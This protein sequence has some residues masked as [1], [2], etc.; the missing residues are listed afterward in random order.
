MENLSG[1][2]RP[3]KKALLSTL[4][5]STL[6]SFCFASG[7]GSADRFIYYITANAEPGGTISPSG[8]V[9]VWR[10]GDKTFEISA[11]TGFEIQ[12][13]LVDG[14]NKGALSTYTFT[15]VNDDHTITASFLARDY[16]IK[17]TAGI[18]GSITPSGDVK[19]KR[20]GKVTFNIAADEG[21]EILDVLVDGESVGAVSRYEFTKVKT[22]HTIHATFKSLFG[23]QDVSIPNESMKIGDVV[24]TTV[25]VSDDSGTPYS[26]VSGSVG[27]YPLVDFQR[28]SATSYLANFSISEGGASFAASEEIP[29]DNLVLSAGG[30]LSPPYNQ[31]IQ[32]DSDPLDAQLP[33]ISSMQVEGGVK[34]IG[35][36]VILTIEADGIS[37]TLDPLST[38]NGMAAT[39]SNMTF[40]ES[41]GGAY[42]L[43]YKVHTGDPDVGPGNQELTAS[44]ILVKPSGNVS[45]PYTTV[46]NASG[47]TIDAHAPVVSRVEVPSLTVGVGGMV[48]ITITA[49]G[50]GYTPGPGSLVNGVPLSSPR[51]TFVEL[52]NG[53]Y[54]L[55]YA[56]DHEDEDVAV[57]MLQ[58]SIQLIDEAGNNSIPYETIEPNSLEIYTTLPEASLGGVPQVC[59]GDEVELTVF[60]SGRMPLSFEMDDGTTTTPYTN[61]TSPEIHIIVAPELT[62]TYQIKSLTDVNGVTN[63]VA[64][65]MQVIVSEIAEV[66]I[67]NL[68][69]GYNVEADGVKL[70]ANIPGGLFS[71]PGVVSSSDYFYPNVA[72]TINSPHTI[73]YTYTNENNCQSI[74]SKLVYV[75]GADGAIVIPEATVC[76][77]SD[78]FTVNVLNIPGTTGTFRLLNSSAQPVSGLTDIGDNTA[79]IDPSLLNP[80]DY[81][82]EF[83][84]VDKVTL[85]LRKNFSVVSNAPPQILTSIDNSYCQDADSFELRSN[86][87]TAIFEGPGVSGNI[88]DGFIFSPMESDPGQI[89]ITCSSLYGNGCSASSEVNVLIMFA[90]EVMFKVNSECL[91][92]GGETVNFENQTPGKSNIETW[93]WDFGD[94]LSGQDNHSNLENPVHHYQEPGLKQISLTA[95]TTEGCVSSYELEASIDSHPE[96]N[97][98]WLSNCYIPGAD[99]KFV[100]RSTGAGSFDTIIWTFRNSTGDLLAEVASEAV[101]DTVAFLFHSAET[102]IVELYTSNGGGCFDEITKQVELGP[103]IKLDSEGYLETYD[104]TEGLWT[105]GSEEQVASWTWGEPNFSGYAGLPDDKAWYTLLPADADYSENS[106]IQSPCFDLTE[107]KR[108][109]IRIDMMRSFVPGMNGAVLQY[110]DVIEEGWKTIGENSPGIGWYNDEHIFNQPGGSSVGWGLEEFT[111]DTD[112]VTAVHDL[113]Q[114]AGKSNVTLRIAFATNGK[115]DLNNQGIAVN[116]VVVSERTKLSLLEH[117]TNYTDDTARL[118]DDRIDVLGNQYYRDF[119]DLQYHVDY[120]GMDPMNKY[121]PDPADERSFMYGIPQIPYSVLDGGLDPHHR[122]GFSE[123][124]TGSIEDH[125]CLLSLEVPAFQMELSVDWLGSDLMA[126]TTIT[127]AADR[128][129]NNIQLYLAV[130]ETSVTA[131]TGPNGDTDFRNVV[132]DMLPSAAGK[133]LGDNWRAGMI[134]AHTHTWSYKPYVEDIDELAVAAFLQDRV[135]GQILQSVVAYK[136]PQTVGTPRIQPEIHNLSTFPNP[137]H[138]LVNVNLG[139]TTEHQGK[140]EILDM[141]GRTVLFE[142]IP[143]G[144]QMVQLDLTHLNR[145]IYILRWTESGLLMGTNKV[146]K[147]R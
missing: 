17:A 138:N 19:V 61:I 31:P 5:I 88:T 48:K 21:Y 60:L 73:V 57:G 2:Y 71:G 122:Y 112:W 126:F 83:E 51:I 84:Y 86:I 133:L 136:T 10:N 79:T 147:A 77:S 146:V 27:G 99:V 106:W 65:G 81:T 40:S 129:S 14:E 116:N 143:A 41:G 18:G 113:D 114:V 135:T 144:Y 29:V 108:P 15:K 145:G 75:L 44:V 134:D 72:D 69:L 140:I 43:H 55:S 111:P 104:E 125:L 64:G 9:F 11:E 127:C 38:F 85:Y 24:H 117:F 30:H 105:V 8:R 47:L 82:I 70:E 109:L 67:I 103:T 96:A 80:E 4:L 137:A 130:F 118:A 39:G 12:E 26:L 28:I 53:L 142:E 33:S 22:T 93:S 66:E 78:P 20:D 92:E 34:K 100:N 58:V 91:P 119:V 50:A 37:Y 13:I 97:F 95:T 132:L 1:K 46:A 23:I 76:S 89:T 52:L 3:G 90:P 120:P 68:E 101:T 141:N 7:S 59:K 94:T 35:D 54:E 139:A 6:F 115:K 121:C 25:T 107:L 98:T 36:V 74:T 131:Y 63:T 123:L 32:Q 49:D 42:A 102:Y 45:L 124:V 87:S 62:T 16:I 110:R 56:I 128:F